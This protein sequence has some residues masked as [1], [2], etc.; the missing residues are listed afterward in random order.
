MGGDAAHLSSRVV[1]ERG[2]VMDLLM[3]VLMMAMRGVKE[4]LSAAAITARSLE[5]TSMRKMTVVT[6]PQLLLRRD[7]HLSFCQACLWT[8]LQDSAVGD[9]TM[10]GEDAALLRILVE[11]ERVIVMEQVM[12]VSMMGTEDAVEIL[13][14][15][16]ITAGSLV[17]TTMR[18]MTVVRGQ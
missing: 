8:L 10:M 12:E 4:T 9:A 14:V 16:A 15:E 17:H 13:C 6:S 11:K 1:W 3:E 2:T 5:H 7:L 18:R